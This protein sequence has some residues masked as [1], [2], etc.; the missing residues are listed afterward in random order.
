[1]GVSGHAVW[2]MLFDAGNGKVP[3]VRRAQLDV[4]GAGWEWLRRLRGQKGGSWVLGVSIHG[5]PWAG[6]AAQLPTLAFPAFSL[7]PRGIRLPPGPWAQPL[8][9]ILALR[10][11]A[12]GTW[13][14]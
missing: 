11:L 3:G 10:R 7:E 2:V 6:T 8:P 4:G 14:P 13:C 12:Y 1:M 5:L 9:I